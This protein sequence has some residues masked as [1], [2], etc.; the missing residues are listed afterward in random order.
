L[1]VVSVAVN[2]VQTS[3]SVISYSSEVLDSSKSTKVDNTTVSQ[4]ALS[5]EIPDSSVSVDTVEVYD[6]SELFVIP[7][8]VDSV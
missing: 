5:V 1:F 7:V 8:S 4:R 6:S 2:S 3:S